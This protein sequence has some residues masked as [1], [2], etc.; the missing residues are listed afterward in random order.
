M[1]SRVPNDKYDK[2][3]SS[4][5]TGYTFLSHFIHIGGSLYLSDEW[6]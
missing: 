4:T 3:V 2:N 6:E 1:G 5:A